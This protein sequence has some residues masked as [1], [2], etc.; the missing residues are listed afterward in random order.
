MKS[1]HI[2]LR[3]ATKDD[4]LFIAQNVLRAL[5][6][7]EPDASRV[8]LMCQICSMDNTLYSWR[9]AVIALN[10][11]VPAGL[12]VAYDGGLYKELRS[13][14]FPLLEHYVGKNWSEQD[15]ETQAGEYY[16][17]SLAVLPQY[18][19][20]GIATTLIKEMLCLKEKAGIPLATIAVDPKNA[21]AYN[22]YRTCGFI[23]SGE[24]H[25]FCTT[26][27]RLVHY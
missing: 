19:C 15:A 7:D 4:A 17:D 3:R 18:R 8:N 11:G 24:I 23:Q 1:D 5:H 13:A 12:M 9:N 16:L 22:L 14:T 6:I 21:T 27:L 26:F 10:N 20:K 25:A 2:I